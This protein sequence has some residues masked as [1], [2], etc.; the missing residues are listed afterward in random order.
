MPLLDAQGRIVRRA[1]GFLRTYTVVDEPKSEKDIDTDAVGSLWTPQETEESHELTGCDR[2]G[3]RK[4]PGFDVGPR[5]AA[6]QER[7]EQRRMGSAVPE[8]R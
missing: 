6:T 3:E 1:I 2:G 4:A 8:V 5:Q 7:F